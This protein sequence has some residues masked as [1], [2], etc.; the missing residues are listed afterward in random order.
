MRLLK[1]K[2]YVDP[3]KGIYKDMLRLQHKD[4]EERRRNKK[5][6]FRLGKAMP[7]EGGWI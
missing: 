5:Q 6:P 4:G 7:V 2:P 3:L 1:R